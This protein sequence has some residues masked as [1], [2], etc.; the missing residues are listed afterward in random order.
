MQPKAINVELD[1]IKPFAAGLQVLACNNGNDTQPVWDDIT[2][3]V[4]AN[5]NHIFTNGA[6]QQG[7][8]YWKVILKIVVMRNDTE[9]DIKLGGV[10]CVLDAKVE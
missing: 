8:T 9:G 1:L 4:R 6:K 10:K 3:A 2:T 7:V 5:I